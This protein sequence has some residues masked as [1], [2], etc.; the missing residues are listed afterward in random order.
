MKSNKIWGSVLIIVLTTIAVSLGTIGSHSQQDTSKKQDNKEVREDWS[1]YLV[2]DYDAPEPANLEEREKR[3]LKNKRYDNQHWVVKN[4][5]PDIV[6]VGLVDEVP[7]PPMIPAVESDFI[8][9]GEIIDANAHLSNDKR[10]VYS[11]YTVQVSEILKEDGL[12]KVK[13]GHSVTVDREGGFVRY[14]NGQKLLYRHSDKDLPQ[15]GSRYVLFLIN[16]ERSPNYRILTGYELKESN[17][18]PLDTAIASENFTGISELNFIK[19]IRNRILESLQP[20]NN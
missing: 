16:A 17:V 1:K 2:V 18:I 19:V 9:V 7:P 4:T 15:I 5:R 20:V 3:K 12:N 8:I 13:L 14:P 6:R 10:G 11:E